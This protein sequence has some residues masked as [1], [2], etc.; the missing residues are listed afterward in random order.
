VTP[1]R[2]AAPAPTGRRTEAVLRAHA[3]YL[4]Y[5]LRHMLFVLRALD[6]AAAPDPRP[7][8][9]ALALALEAGL[10]AGALADGVGLRAVIGLPH[11]PVSFPLPPAPAA[12]P[13]EDPGARRTRVE[14]YAAG[15]RGDDPGPALYEVVRAAG[16]W[17]AALPPQDRGLLGGL[18][19]TLNADGT[20][21]TV[22]VLPHGYAPPGPQA[23]ARLVSPDS[24]ESPESPESPD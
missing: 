23:R 22:S 4:A 10:P 16:R 9:R 12:D 7:V 14:A 13:R 11:G 24:P 2:T 20:G 6:E 1:G 17:L 5:V 8:A 15:V 19:V 3:R 18:A 21:T